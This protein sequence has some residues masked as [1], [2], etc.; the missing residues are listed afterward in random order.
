MIQENDSYSLRSADFDQFTDE[1]G[2]FSLLF[3][4]SDII[5]GPFTD[6]KNQS[7]ETTE[8]DFNSFDGYD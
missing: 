7:L 6:M 4:Y 3:R 8:M 5:F 2:E 1:I